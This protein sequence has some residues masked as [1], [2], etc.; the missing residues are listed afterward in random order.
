MSIDKNT[1]EQMSAKSSTA[2]I[3]SLIRANTPSHLYRNR[4]NFT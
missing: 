4:G 2:L 1:K 3:I